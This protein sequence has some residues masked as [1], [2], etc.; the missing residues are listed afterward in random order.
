MKQ[1]YIILMLAGLMASAGA[2]T[3]QS[4]SPNNSTIGTMALQVE[5]GGSNFN[6]NQGTS[7][8]VIFS[9]QASGYEIYGYY[10]SSSSSTAA[11]TT[12]DIDYTADTGP[13]DLTINDGNS[14]LTLNN[15]F[16][17]MAE[18]PSTPTMSISPATASLNTSVE[19]QVN[20]HLTHFLTGNASFYIQVPGY[21][22]S[23]SGQVQQILNDSIA[24]VDFNLFGNL[25]PGAYNFY[26][27]DSHD[28]LVLSLNQFTI[29]GSAPIITSA[30]PD[31]AAADS[32][33]QVIIS[34][35]FTNFSSATSTE[36]VWLDKDGFIIFPAT[37][38]VLGST[39]ICQFAIPANAPDGWYDIHTF[40][41]LDG[42][43]VKKAGFYI[44]GGVSGIAQ[45]SNDVASLK[46]FPNPATD[47]V[48][49]IPDLDH[50]QWVTL[51]VT[52]IAGQVINRK[53]VL[54]PVGK[55]QCSLDV[56]QFAAGLYTVNL[57]AGDKQ[58]RSQFVV[59]R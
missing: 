18:K 16:T 54:I 7:T 13:Y 58:L 3:L 2:Q 1:L 59:I 41:Y 26:A 43:L 29:T 37:P 6:F 52:N 55:A 20:G 40:D 10:F 4:V 19:V 44:Y 39:D 46:L 57:D 36:I 38:I 34:G 30:D 50:D 21:G 42:A 32:S 24:I 27:Q 48:I 47:N 25:V 45:V 5:I 49:L 35:A 23:F 28:N 56:S 51:T 8:Q 15:A 17:V 33:L 31:S 11:Y 22:N 12:I 9:S 14:I 53:R